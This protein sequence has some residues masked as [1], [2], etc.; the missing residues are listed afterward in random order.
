MNRPNQFWYL[1]FAYP[2]GCGAQ[3]VVSPCHPFHPDFLENWMTRVAREISQTGKIIVQPETV[4][5]DFMHELP[6]EVA[7]A[8][9]PKYFESTNELLGPSS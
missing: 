4:T 2:G 5:I 6:Q 9:F 8:R 7:K 3:I 1:H